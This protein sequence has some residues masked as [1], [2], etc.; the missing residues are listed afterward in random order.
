MFPAVYEGGDSVDDNTGL[1]STESVDFG[2]ESKNNVI[3][4]R[5]SELVDQP[6]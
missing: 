1:N 4:S 6:Q 5:H 3:T 2:S